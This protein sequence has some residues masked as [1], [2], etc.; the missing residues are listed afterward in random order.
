MRN[1]N[2]LNHKINVGASLLLGMILSSYLVGASAEGSDRQQELQPL[3]QRSTALAQINRPIAVPPM[4]AN[5]NISTVNGR[6][7]LGSHVQANDV[8]TV[9][10]A[11]IATTGVILRNLTTINGAITL[12][13]AVTVRGDIESVNGNVQVTGASELQGDLQTVNG[14]IQLSGSRVWRSLRTSNGNIVLRKA[15]EVLGDIIVDGESSS[16]P[17]W[18]GADNMPSLTIDASS[19]VKGDIHLHQ[20]VQLQ[21]DE[22]ASVGKIYHHYR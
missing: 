21:I 14:D 12:Q 1:F 3:A 6:I 18:I 13:E 19:S 10:G 11:V 5:G 7:T 2:H 20:A 16:M 8:E 4:T 9:N 22:G 17:G 15:A